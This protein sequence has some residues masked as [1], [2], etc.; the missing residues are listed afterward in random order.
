MTFKRIVSRCAVITALTAAMGCDG[1]TTAA[2]DP[3]EVFDGPLPGLTAAERAAFVRGDAA[4]G[5]PFS[6]AEGLG[7]IFN[8]VSCASCHSADGR[9][10]PANALTR[11]GSGS[12]LLRHLGG[13]QLQDRA[14]PGAVAEQLPAGVAFSLRLP[15][16]VFG[17]GLIEA[18]A[19]ETILAFADPA[20]VNGDGISGRPNWVTAPDYV[21]PGEVGGGTAPRLG[22]FSRKAQVGSLMSQVTEAYHQDMGITSDLLPVENVNPLASGATHAADRVADPELPMQELQAVVAYVRM[23]AAPAPGALTEQR[24]LGQTLFRA[25]GCT[26][27]HVPELRTGPNASAALSLQ[28]VPLYSDLLLHDMGD[29]LADHRPDA[30]A[31]GREWRTAPLWGLRL[32]RG[33]LNGDAFLLH[34]GRARTVE[35]AILLHGGEAL[36]SRNAFAALSPAERAAVVDF[37]GS[38]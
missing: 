37:V 18:I 32:M 22:R 8:N 3:G 31:D 13:P 19:E 38:R 15:P 33:F 25:A 9:G 5:R 29:A 20:D 12:D 34:D 28:P 6:P 17:M 30:G 23:L 1:V 2:P 4:F 10:R 21:P 7:P 14:I 35:E 16:P 24:Q 36:A 11:F 27:C 26:G